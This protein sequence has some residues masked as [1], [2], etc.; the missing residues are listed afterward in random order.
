[1]SSANVRVNMAAAATRLTSDPGLHRLDVIGPR[2]R[3]A[4]FSRYRRQVSFDGRDEWR[5]VTWSH[6]CL[7]AEN[8]YW[9]WY[10]RRPLGRRCLT[11]ALFCRGKG[12]LSAGLITRINFGKIETFSPVIARQRHHVRVL[13]C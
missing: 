8:N 13:A 4:Q 3:R 11:S 2:S 9:S 5:N 12:A 6:V 7:C 1:M 10:A